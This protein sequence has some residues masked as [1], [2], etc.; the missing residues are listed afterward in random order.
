MG[1]IKHPHIY[2]YS[3]HVCPENVHR[4]PHSTSEHLWISRHTHSGAIVHPHVLTEADP[5]V[6]GLQSHFAA[7]R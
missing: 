4:C 2:L 5:P 6:L 7:Q 1:V 3:P